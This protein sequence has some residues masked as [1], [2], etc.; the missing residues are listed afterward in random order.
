MKEKL[1]RFFQG[2]YGSD[3]F[4]R[5]L[6]IASLVLILISLFTAKVWGGRLSSLLWLMGLAL[7][8]YGF[9]RMLSKNIYK[10][11]AENRKYYEVSGKV[12]NW[13]A[14]VK[15]RLKDLKGYKYFHC[16]ACKAT[17]RVPRH[18]G[19]VK[20]TCKKCGETFMGKT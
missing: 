6:S 12:K 4:S 18:K 14:G 10:R 11:Q 20:I 1:Q 17:L 15:Q 9:I 16:P 19:Q 13:F 3:G 8:I 7:L 2:R 5:F